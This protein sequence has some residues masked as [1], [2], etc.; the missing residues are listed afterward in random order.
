MKRLGYLWEAHKKD[1]RQKKLKI[2]DILAQI[3]KGR[4]K[5][6]NIITIK[7]LERYLNKKI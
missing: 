5:F 3:P 6:R 7:D 1:I 2:Y 4:R